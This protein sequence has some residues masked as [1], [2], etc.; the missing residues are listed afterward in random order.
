MW[1]ENI[2]LLSVPDFKGKRQIPPLPC[3]NPSIAMRDN[4]KG[5]LG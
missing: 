3:M 2:T 1:C 5:Y 4:K